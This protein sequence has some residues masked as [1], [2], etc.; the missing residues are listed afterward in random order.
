MADG[1]GQAELPGTGVALEKGAWR[2]RTEREYA[3]SPAAVL[4]AHWCHEAGE[5]RRVPMDED[6]ARVAVYVAA[7]TGDRFYLGSVAGYED[8]GRFYEEEP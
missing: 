3:A 1:M 4:Q 8:A 6:T 5:G 2:E 7:H